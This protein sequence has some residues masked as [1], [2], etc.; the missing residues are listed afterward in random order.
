MF[1]YLL[2]KLID[3]IYNI[4]NENVEFKVKLFNDDIIAPF[5]ADP[6]AA[7]YDV[8]STKSV[9]IPYGERCLIPLGF[10]VQVP[11]YYYL[12]VAPRSGLSLR[13]IDI[14]A[15]VIDSSYRG[16]VMV[17]VV[18][19][20]GDDYEVNE[21]DKIAQ[22]IMERCANTEIDICYEY[23]DSDSDA[24]HVDDLTETSRGTGG[25]GST[26]NSIKTD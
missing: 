1:D 15:G 3:K 2:K 25:F 21:G 11:D 13:G 23:S 12:R 18:N 9:I 19:N 7:G 24:D 4:I 22:L 20:T 8:F 16:E 5:K 26:G 17:L 10:A 14:G 6:G